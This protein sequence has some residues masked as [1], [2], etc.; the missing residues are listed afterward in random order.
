MIVVFNTFYGFILIFFSPSLEM[1]LQTF[2]HQPRRSNQC[3][4]GGELGIGRKENET[5]LYI[6]ISFSLTCIGDVAWTAS[7]RLQQNCHARGKQNRNMSYQF[8]KL[9]QNILQCAN[10][11]GDEHFFS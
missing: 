9:S 10:V 2:H 7:K 1:W 6:Y 11:E 8:L 4:L 3:R 5:V